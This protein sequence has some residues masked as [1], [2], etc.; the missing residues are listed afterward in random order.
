MDDVAAVA[1]AVLADRGARASRWRACRARTRARSTPRRTPRTCTRASR[2]TT[3][4]SRAASSAAR[5]ERRRG[6]NEK[7]LSER[8]QRRPPPGDERTDA[9]QQDQRQP[10]GMQEEVVVRLRDR[11]RL[12][13]HRLRQQ[14]IHDAPEDRQAERDEQQVVV[15]ERRLARHERLELRSRAQQRQP[16]VDEPDRKDGADADEAEEP[17]AERALRERVDR[18]DHARAREERAEDREQ[19]ASA[20]STMFQTF[21]IPRFSWI[22]TECRNAVAASHGMSAAFSTGSQA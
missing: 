15:E 5:D 18:V 2:A 14:R 9:H 1:T 11:A 6:R 8:A 10:E 21:S 7:R 12:T 22:I 16:V 19:N 3:S 17:A 20:T 13:A 4:R